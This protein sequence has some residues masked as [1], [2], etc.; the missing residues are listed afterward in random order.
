MMAS[1]KEEVVM[2]S[3]AQSV[4]IGGALSGHGVSNADRVALVC[5]HLAAA[6]TI[7]PLLYRRSLT[8]MDWYRPA[9]GQR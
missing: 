3:F 1:C 5:M 8:S 7:V 4:S 2:S 9:R 6:A